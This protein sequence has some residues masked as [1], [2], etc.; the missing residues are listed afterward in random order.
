CQ[1]VANGHTGQAIASLGVFLVGGFGRY[2]WEI[3]RF[4]VAH[5]GWHARGIGVIWLHERSPRIPR[6]TPPERSSE[7]QALCDYQLRPCP[8]MTQLVR[9]VAGNAEPRLTIGHKDST[10]HR[11]SVAYQEE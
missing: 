3:C 1:P 9:L 6:H 7:K 11:D 10:A 4:V 5:T 2:L 8:T